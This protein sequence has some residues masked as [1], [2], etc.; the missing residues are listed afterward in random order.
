MLP[1]KP[2]KDRSGE[3]GALAAVVA[4]VLLVAVYYLVKSWISDP[5]PGQSPTERPTTR[6]E[7][8]QAAPAE[9]KGDLNLIERHQEIR[10]GDRYLV[11][12]VKNVSKKTFSYVE[13]SYRLKDEE[14]NIVGNAM[15][16]T[17]TLRPGETWKFS[18]EASKGKSYELEKLEGTSL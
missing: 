14:G 9:P 17:G 4:L 5:P 12:I 16:N 15:T 10:D 18:V 11:G 1:V 8:T 13:I 6:P 3:L 2:K 7:I